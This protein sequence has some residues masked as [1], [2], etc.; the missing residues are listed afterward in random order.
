MLLDVR[1]LKVSFD[2]PDGVVE[3]V[4]G[5]D[6]RLAAGES[7]GIVGESGSGKSQSVLALMG[8]LA[9]NARVSGSA[10]LQTDTGALEL[11]GAK[12][13]V[14]ERI[15][16]ARIAMIFQDPMTTLN[17]HL[18]IATQIKEVITRHRGLRGRAA[19]KA[20]IEMLEAVKIPDPAR[21]IRYYPH[22]FSGGMRQRVMIAMALACEPDILIADEP[23]TALDVTVQA[24]ILDLMAELRQRTNVA[25][26]LITH[27]LGVVA[28][29]CERLLVM[30]HGEVVERGAIDPIFEAPAHAYTRDLLAAVPKLETPHFA[31]ASS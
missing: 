10:T 31:R 7:V 30:R 11:I 3:A 14:L 5:L 26:L 19:T 6:L 21:R 15:R 27:D 29:Q 2:T 4:R 22:Q 1:D 8:L 20:A 9:D 18:R 17:P 12:R 28:G 24:D 23:T 25:L 13:R 16:G